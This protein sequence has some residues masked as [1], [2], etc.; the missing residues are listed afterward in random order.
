[1]MD[2]IIR[3]KKKKEERTQLKKKKVK[4]IAGIQGTNRREST[5]G[6]YF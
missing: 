2:N 4:H 6:K 5:A 1:M 3:K